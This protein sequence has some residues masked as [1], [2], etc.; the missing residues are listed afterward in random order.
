MQKELTQ[1]NISKTTI[2]TVAFVSSV[3]YVLLLFYF[4]EGRNS[5]EGLFNTGNMFGLLLYATPAMG[6][7]ILIFHILKKHIKN[8]N[9]L[10]IS[11]L[12]GPIA[13]FSCILGLFF[14]VNLLV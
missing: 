11:A 3:F 13:G 6:F 10:I 1:N 2:I 14:L 9:A 7:V 5:F 8:I 12:I 4:D